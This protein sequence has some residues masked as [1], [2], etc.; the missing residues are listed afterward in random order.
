M[1][2]ILLITTLFFTILGFSQTS[3]NAKADELIKQI[4]QQ[5]NSK[6]SI[7]FTFN[8]KTYKDKA[9]FLDTDKKTFSIGTSLLS[10][11]IMTTQI[12]LIVDKKK[13]G[14]YAIVAGNKNGSVVVISGKYYQFVGT[15][16]LVVTGKKVAGTFAGEL[17]EIKKGKG[18][19]DAKSSG[20]ISGSFAE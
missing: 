11:K 15:V 4:Q 3:G 16:K 6:S 18:R 10:E 2:K 12:N 5:Q 9:S 7:S 14:T 1:K 19:P 8:K 13:T 17:Y 20:P